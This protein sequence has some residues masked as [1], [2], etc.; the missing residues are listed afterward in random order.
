MWLDIERKTRCFY[1][2]IVK[3]KKKRTT[4]DN[5]CCP[6][7]TI[8]PRVRNEKNNPH[9]RIK[10]A[11]VVVHLLVAAVMWGGRQRARR[12][13]RFRRGAAGEMP[14][15]KG[16][17]P[18]RNNIHFLQTSSSD[19]IPPIKL[20]YRQSSRRTLSASAVAFR[21]VPAKLHEYIF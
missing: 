11:T 3:K 12:G 1:V 10:H 15:E 16:A 2:R 7:S 9:G 4:V 5:R 13:R 20:D 6:E 8:Y 14:P 19:P 17:T 18:R 21:G